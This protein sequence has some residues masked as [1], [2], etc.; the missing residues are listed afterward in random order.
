MGIK[1]VDPNELNG[2]NEITGKTVAKAGDLTFKV[3]LLSNGKHG[4]SSEIICR[5]LK[6]KDMK[7]LIVTEVDNEIEYIKRLSHVL[8]NTI[9]EPEGFNIE[10]VSHADFV[11]IILAHR[12]NSLGSIYE[13]VYRCPS[14][15][16]TG[17]S[18]RIDL[19]KLDEKKLASGYPGDPVKLNDT[20]SY[21]YPRISIFTKSNK[22]MI[23]DITDFD[24]FEDCLRESNVSVD[25]IDYVDYIKVIEEIR[26]WDY[27]IE[28]NY[29]TKCGNCK[30]EVKL[31]IP[32]FLLLFR[33]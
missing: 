17:Q 25:D 4:Y 13:L 12:I 5:P 31:G 16:K 7:S 1:M 32:F 18:V 26:K 2:K 8:S 22:T 30:Q 19:A 28:T 24:L 14:C 6:I 29:K 33:R 23:D 3:R 21:R 15:D 9:L 27:G 10:D 11:K 20:I